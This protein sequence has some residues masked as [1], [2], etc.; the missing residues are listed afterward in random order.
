[1]RRIILGLLIAAGGSLVLAAGVAQLR[2][3]DSQKKARPAGHRMTRPSPARKVSHLA[4]SPPEQ[5]KAN[6][7]DV[8][9]ICSRNLFKPACNSALGRGDAS[10]PSR[11]FF[12]T[13]FRTVRLSGIAF[14]GKD[15]QALIENEAAGESWYVRRGDKVCGMA[16]EVIAQDHVI[17]S[18]GKKRQRLDLLDPPAR[19]TAGPS[20]VGKGPLPPARIIFPLPAVGAGGKAP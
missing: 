1:M 17:L 12:P 20:S 2:N 10:A 9:A 6:P 8:G 7:A 18:D 5:P 14:D 16:L 3:T 11:S 15:I 19:P 4:S 13:P